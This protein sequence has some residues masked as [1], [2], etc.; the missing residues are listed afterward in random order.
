MSDKA[1]ENIGVSAPTMVCSDCGNRIPLDLAVGNGEWKT[2]GC[3]NCGLVIHLC[4][5]TISEHRFR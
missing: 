2:L 5:G 1:T 4:R 3:P